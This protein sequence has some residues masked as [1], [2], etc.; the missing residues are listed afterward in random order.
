M[1][2]RRDYREARCLVTGASSGLGRAL[3]VELVRRGAQ[4]VLTGR[5][6]DRLDGTV[7]SLLDSGARPEAVL[8]VPADLTRPDDRRRLADAVADRFGGALDILVNSAGVGA[9]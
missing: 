9:Y 3:A 6:A 7:R 2:R 5:S 4:V 1:P 8:A